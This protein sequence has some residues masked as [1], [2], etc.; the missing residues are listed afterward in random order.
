MPVAWEPQHGL[1][2][3][4]TGEGRHGCTCR[5]V[6]VRGGLGRGWLFS[7]WFGSLEDMRQSL[8]REPQD[9]VAFAQGVW[10]V[11]GD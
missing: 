11:R 10:G 2:G 1:W 5:H 6:P 4:A 9:T 8:E 3:S 7:A